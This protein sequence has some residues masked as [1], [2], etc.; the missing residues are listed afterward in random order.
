M[1]YWLNKNNYHDFSV[2][3]KNRLPARSYFIPYPTREEADTTAAKEKRY[4]SSKVQCLNGMWDF[5]FYP[6]PA[7]LPDV[8]DTDQ[9]SFDTIDVPAC[10]QFRGYDKPFYVNTRYQFPYHPPVIPTE[11]TGASAHAGRIRE[12]NII[13]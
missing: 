7:E 1:K 13:L 6:R 2:Y 3:Q 11:E 4:R 5:K 9:V 8:F 12:K 10:W